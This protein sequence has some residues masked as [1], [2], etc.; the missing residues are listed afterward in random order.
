MGETSAFWI[1]TRAVLAA[2]VLTLLAFGPSL[3]QVVCGGEWSGKAVAAES[4]S[5]ATMMS[6]MS[7]S[8]DDHAKGHAGDA[9][10]L[11]SH[12]HCHH[13]S[14]FVGASTGAVDPVAH[15][16]DVYAFALSSP[17]VTDIKFGL[18]RPPRA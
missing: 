15:V 11:C 14:T 5:P 7:G 6:A 12:G 3:D 17:A 9:A 8:Q 2:L 16:R 13:G 10:G 1:K 18:K 4:T